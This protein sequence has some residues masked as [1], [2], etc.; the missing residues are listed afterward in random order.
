MRRVVKGVYLLAAPQ[1]FEPRYADPELMDHIGDNPWFP[2][3]N[4]IIC[5]RLKPARKH[6]DEVLQRLDLAHSESKRTAHLR[7]TFF[8]RH[9]V[10][11][12]ANY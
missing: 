1:G 7:H 2:A 5:H 6:F 11:W 9:K 4:S 3:D 10:I 8:T 12:L